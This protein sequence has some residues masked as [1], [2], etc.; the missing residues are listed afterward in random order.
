MII[1]GPFEPDL[2]HTSGGKWR[3]L[4]F[5]IKRKAASYCFMEAAFLRF[6]GGTHQFSGGSHTFSGG[7]PQFSGGSYTFSGGTPW[8]TSDNYK[9]HISKEWKLCQFEN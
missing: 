8:S 2:V 7:I 3:H 1:Y 4:L 6:S 5:T 9:I